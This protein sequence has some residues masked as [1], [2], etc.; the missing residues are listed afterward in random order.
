MILGAGGS[1]TPGVGS[2]DEQGRLEDLIRELQIEGDVELVGFA[3]NPYQYM[4]RAAVFVLSS[5]WEGLPTV[6]IEAMACG[7]PVVSTDCP[8]GPREILEDGKWGRLVPVG[9]H[10]ELAAAILDALRSPGVDPRA[11]AEDFSL[12]RCASQYLELLFPERQ[13]A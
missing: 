8:H 4:S 7:S 1:E 2:R 12:E 13:S 5:K 3:S 6:L 9:S 11:R 10:E